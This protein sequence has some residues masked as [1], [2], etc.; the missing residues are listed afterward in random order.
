MISAAIS[1]AMLATR[2]GRSCR[3]ATMARATAK[4]RANERLSAI[5]GA[6]VGLGTGEE[7]SMTRLLWS[8]AGVDTRATFSA[9]SFVDTCCQTSQ[10]Q[11]RLSYFSGESNLTLI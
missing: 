5:R 2:D 10:V 6:A 3:S 4:A 7:V 8:L 9:G 1:Q 11:N